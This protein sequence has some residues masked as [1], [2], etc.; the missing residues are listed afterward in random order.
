MS[1]GSYDLLPGRI[2]SEWSV[3]FERTAG[4]V[5]GL[6]VLAAVIIAVVEGFGNGRPEHVFMAVVLSLL[7]VF[8]TLVTRRYLQDVFQERN[9]VYFGGFTLLL[10]A[11]ATMMYAL[12]WGKI[13]LTPE[14]EALQGCTSDTTASCYNPL[15]VN[16]TTGAGGC[17]KF[18]RA[19]TG[20]SGGGGGGREPPSSA[21][22]GSSCMVFNNNTMTFA[23][24]FSPAPSNATIQC[25]FASQALQK[26]GI[27]VNCTTG[28]RTMT[29]T[30]TGA[31]VAPPEHTTPGVGTSPI[32]EASDA[33][34]PTTVPPTR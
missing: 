29:I 5:I 17:I 28:P 33:A 21:P 18:P 15:V 8:W 32:S 14:Q 7:A 4:F 30:A 19:L 3:L 9:I 31:T 22:K 11:T 16:P 2:Q 13:P 6:V 26:C 20:G 34:N 27:S 24:L 1:K 12:H 10:V 25:Q 23:A